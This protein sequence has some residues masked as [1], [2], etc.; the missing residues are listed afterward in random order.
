[1]AAS[2]SKSCDSPEQQ[3]RVSHLPD[4]LNIGSNLRHLSPNERLNLTHTTRSPIRVRLA[5]NFKET[6][7]YRPEHYKMDSKPRGYA[8]VVNNINFN[9]EEL[10]P[11]RK[12]A[13]NDERSIEEMLKQFYFEV[14]T[15]RN[16]KQ[17]EMRVIVNNFSQ[18]QDFDKV[19]CVFVVF[20]SHGAEGHS[21]D[22][23]EV[24][25]TDGIGLKTK[26][27]VSFFFSDHCP[28]LVH[29]PKIFV[30]QS[31]RG[32]LSDPGVTVGQ[33][34]HHRTETDG[35]RMD[36]LRAYYEKVRTMSDIF[37][38]HPV[39]PGRSANRD[40][41]NGAWFIQAIVKIFS[42]HAHD[43]SIEDLF[44]LVD[45]DIKQMNNMKEDN[46][47]AVTIT[48]MGWSKILYFNPGLYKLDGKT[49]RE[50]PL[51]ELISVPSR[52]EGTDTVDIIRS[53]GCKKKKKYNR[54]KDNHQNGEEEDEDDQNIGCCGTMFSNCRIRKRTTSLP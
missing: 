14:E 1:M 34:Y 48:V 41:Y 4:Y 15:H 45:R 33:I 53:N 40:I 13:E 19:D 54:L 37:I 24:M 16:K 18:K 31:C 26:D 43:C 50:S 23:T 35:R 36:Q 25:G 12:G 28:K 39:A 8:L 47:Q 52:G 2:T 38:A 7:E 44:K 29:K 49:I 42:A 20:M 11:T 9:D 32:N 22:D 6:D 5:R 10:Y 17:Q 30:F 51:G 27:I 3:N 21:E 46:F